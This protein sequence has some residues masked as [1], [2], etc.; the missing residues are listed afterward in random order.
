MD[1][2]SYLD[3]IPVITHYKVN[4]ELTDRF[5]FPAL[6]DYA[7]AV[8]EYVDGWNRD[9]SGARSWED[10][11]EEAQNYITMIEKYAE[12]PVRYISVGAERESIVI[13]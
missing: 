2:L 3:R 8:V 4:G 1:V 5:P 6:L 7:E 12:C 13:R 11:P 10:L 9:I